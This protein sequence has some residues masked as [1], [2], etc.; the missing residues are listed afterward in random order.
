MEDERMA[1]AMN[2]VYIRENPATYLVSDAEYALECARSA[3]DR[4]DDDAATRFARVAILLYAVSLEG[5]INFVY[6]YSEVPRSTWSKLSFRDRW[7]NAASLCLPENGVLEVNDVVVYRPGDPIETFREDAEPF[8]SFLELKAFRNRSIHLMP[9]YAQI[10]RE[11]VEAHLAREE[12]YPFSGL[13]MRLQLCSLEHA[14]TAS[15]IYRA[16]TQELDRQMKGT[17][18]KHFATEGGA[19]LEWL[20]SEEDDVEWDEV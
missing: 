15:R 3:N 1:R 18:L 6:E 10:E 7:L 5:F 8:V 9:P 17:I 4:K 12:Y 14:E 13:P 2:Q 19:V 11:E 20:C 16:M